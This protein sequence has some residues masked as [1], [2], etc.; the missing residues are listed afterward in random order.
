M[1][2]P[3]LYS[4]DSGSSLTQQGPGFT[5]KP[6]PWQC[7]C[8]QAPPCVL[9]QV[10]QHATLHFFHLTC[11]SALSVLGDNSERIRLGNVFS[12][13]QIGLP[14][15]NNFAFK[16]EDAN[17]CL[18]HMECH[19]HVSAIMLSSILDYGAF[20]RG[21]SRKHSKNRIIPNEIVILFLKGRKLPTCR[22][23]SKL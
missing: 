20:L 22:K 16:R 5:S 8:S 18:L 15:E 11:C 9:I 17:N 10:A 3:I 1:N 12:E 7:C 4:E 14:W 6:C 21:L 13:I 2:D 23:I 19:C